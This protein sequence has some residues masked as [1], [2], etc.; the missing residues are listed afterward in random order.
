MRP[1]YIASD[2][3]ITSLGTTTLANMD[4]LKIGRIGIRMTSDSHLYPSPVPL[5][6][7]DTDLLEELFQSLLKEYH[8]RSSSADFTRLEKLFIL[9][10]HEAIIGLPLDY[11]DQKTL[12]ILST[13]KGNID[14]LEE[15]NGALF[16]PQRIYLWELARI[17]DNFFGFS[18][19]PVVI[20]NA[21]I[22]GVIALITAYRYL[23]SGLYDQAVVCGGDIL[24]EFVISGF[25]SFQSLSPSPCR[26]FD[27]Q[28]DGLS[29]GEGVGTMVLTT[30]A[31]TGTAHSVTIK[32]A[33]TT[34][35][36]NHISGPSRTG[37]ELGMAIRNTMK[38]AKILPG[39][40]GFIN[41]HGTATRFND[42]ME[43]KAIASAGL[44]EV[45]VNS[46]K[47]FWGHTMGAAGLIESVASVQALREE[48]LIKT[49]GFESLG[50][51]EPIRV[52]ACNEKKAMKSCLKS[53][54]GFGGCNASILFEKEQP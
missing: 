12:F 28:R 9:S 31:G 45:P 17:V 37:E 19:P 39:D 43:S 53:A 51:P 30:S 15:E 18:T 11:R 13:T 32:G 38:E 49:A 7:V 50:V 35:D 24:S 40:I 5:S 21:C 36:A 26:P 52:T 4:A 54:S 2:N 29:L 20:S 48:L 8:P 46:F 22:S 10:I 33:A 42:E 27:A 47:G 16:P 44:L 3:I 41:A 1:V 14:L 6:L 23:G 25:Q 34:N